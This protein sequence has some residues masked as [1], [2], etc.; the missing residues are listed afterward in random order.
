MRFTQRHIDSA[1][2][3]KTKPAKQRCDQQQANSHCAP[4]TELHPVGSTAPH[5]SSIAVADGFTPG[6]SGS[7][8]F[9]QAPWQANASRR[10]P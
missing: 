5:V 1:V 2:G 3:S 8:L 4:H 6:P 9:H 7:G 10:L